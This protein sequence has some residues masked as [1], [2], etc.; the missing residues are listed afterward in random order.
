RRPRDGRRWSARPA[1][2]GGARMSA[3]EA[4]LIDASANVRDAMQRIDGNRNGIALVVDDRRRL[5]GTVT[6]GDIRRAMLANVAL[7][8]PVAVLLERQAALGEDR[9]I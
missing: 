4:M 9:P 1:V 5:V 3:L 2:A 8:E 6:D 7:S